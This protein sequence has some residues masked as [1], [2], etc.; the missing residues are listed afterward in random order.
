V[1]DKLKDGGKLVVLL[2]P[3]KSHTQMILKTR[4]YWTEGRY[5][6]AKDVYYNHYKDYLRPD[7]LQ[8]IQAYNIA[9]SLSFSDRV[10]L[11]V[12]SKGSD[13]LSKKE[14]QILVT[15]RALS[16]MERLEC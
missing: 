3:N 4:L 8:F 5:D 11:N 15:H 13:P 16:R 9:K 12:K 14:M 7:Q 1:L 2:T 10:D 6:L